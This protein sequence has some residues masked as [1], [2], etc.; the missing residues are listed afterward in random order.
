MARLVEEG[1][2]YYFQGCN[3]LIC[4][5]DQVFEDG[6]FDGLVL[7]LETGRI[8]PLVAATSQCLDLDHSFESLM[9]DLKQRALRAV[10]QSI[11]DF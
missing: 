2:Y 8:M 11:T 6:R 7:N 9:P 5:V 3:L 10:S 4:R 1:G